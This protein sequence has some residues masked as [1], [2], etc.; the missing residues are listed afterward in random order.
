MR[1]RTFSGSGKREFV[2]VSD[3]V[4]SF[5]SGVLIIDFVRSPSYPFES[6]ASNKIE[7]RAT[8]VSQM[9]VLVVFRKT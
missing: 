9:Q 5:C 1:N 4:E 6:Y 2:P 7:S 8:W 3:F